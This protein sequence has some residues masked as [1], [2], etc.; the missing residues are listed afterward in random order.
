MCFGKANVSSFSVT[1]EGAK[2]ISFV[3]ELEAGLFSGEDEGR[4]KE[5]SYIGC[6]T[7]IGFI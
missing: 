1:E 4:I 7:T 2:L 5:V 6:V 3:E